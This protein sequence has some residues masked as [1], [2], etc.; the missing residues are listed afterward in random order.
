MGTDMHTKQ[1]E[2]EASIP[3]RACGVKER[4]SFGTNMAS[5]EVPFDVTAAYHASGGLRHGMYVESY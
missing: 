2:G 4:V 3:G 5:D 1:G